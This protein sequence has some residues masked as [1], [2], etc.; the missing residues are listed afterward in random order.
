MGCTHR[1]THSCTQ[2]CEGT[3]SDMEI[4]LFIPACTVAS[5]TS[6]KGAELDEG[7]LGCAKRAIHQHA[8]VQ[9]GGQTWE[10]R[11]ICMHVLMNGHPLIKIWD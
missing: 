6:D 9:R 4:H 11:W 8:A 1:A 2:I 10:V 3:G 5:T 7:W